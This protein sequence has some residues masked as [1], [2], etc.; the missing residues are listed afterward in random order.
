MLGHR[1]RSRARL[2]ELLA[3]TGR[4]SQRRS[5]NVW[6]PPC[7][8]RDE[9]LI[10]SIESRQEFS[11]HSQRHTSKLIL[12]SLQDRTSN[13]P[14]TINEKVVLPLVRAHASIIA[15]SAPD[16]I[17]HHFNTYTSITATDEEQ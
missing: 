12:K 10:L 9:S 6:T 14:V 16:A 3:L 11:A 4:P 13:R 1:G 7:R 15:G 17:I 8:G 5:T 2:L